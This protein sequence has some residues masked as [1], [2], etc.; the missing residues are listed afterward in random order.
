M[1]PE[2][3]FDA[4]CQISAYTPR[5][6][7]E[8]A[9]PPLS[10]SDSYRAAVRR[11][12]V[13]VLTP[14]ESSKVDEL[15]NSILSVPYPEVEELHQEVARLRDRVGTI[16]VRIFRRVRPLNGW[17]SSCLYRLREGV[18]EV[19]SGES[20]KASLFGSKT[21]MESVGHEF[22]EVTGDGE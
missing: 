17:S 9:A 16:P 4:G 14:Y 7:P 11:A 1:E 20:W 13:R 6:Q 15:V 8:P 5:V 3:I 19:G 2:P 18:W 21:A 10:T 22:V 12:I